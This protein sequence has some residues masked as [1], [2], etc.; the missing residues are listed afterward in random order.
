MEEVI[1]PSFFPL[2]IP[3]ATLF[4]W[5]YRVKKWRIEFDIS[6]DNDLVFTGGTSVGSY[7]GTRVLGSTGGGASPAASEKEMACN[8]Y[9]DLNYTY[10]SSNESR[11]V[12][13]ELPPDPPDTSACTGE[14]SLKFGVSQLTYEGTDP[15]YG[16]VTD[17]QRWLR[18]EADVVGGN[19][20]FDVDYIIELILTISSNDSEPISTCYRLGGVDYTYDLSGVECTMDGFTIPVYNIYV[21]GTA[22]QSSTGTISITP[23]EYWEYDPDDGLGPIYDSSDGSQLRDPFSC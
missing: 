4:K 10:S 12:V 2:Q 16:V 9:G 20:P 5:V 14:V 18:L 19:V 6:F 17:L 1:T 11:T 7:A 13:V 8:Y 23:E 3:L 22:S 15:D 21:G